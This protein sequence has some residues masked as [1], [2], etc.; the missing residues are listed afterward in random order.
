M[1]APYHRES[2]V[3]QQDD[4]GPRHYLNGSPVQEGDT[5]EVRSAMGWVRGC[6][7]WSGRVEFWP[8]LALHPDDGHDSARLAVLRR[9]GP[10]TPCRWPNASD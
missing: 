9:F 3:L 6:Y 5:I 8:R 10:D 4:T 2:L 7:A 1:R